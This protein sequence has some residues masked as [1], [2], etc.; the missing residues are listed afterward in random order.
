MS[1]PVL[2]FFPHPN[3]G[4][5]RGGTVGRNFGAI[6]R[7]H[8]TGGSMKETLPGG[9]LAVIHGVSNLLMEEILHQLM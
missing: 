1:S 7:H 8:G 3:S 5:F 2:V 9:P 4:D 6:E